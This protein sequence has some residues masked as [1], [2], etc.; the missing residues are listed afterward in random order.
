MTKLFTWREIM[1]RI[2]AAKGVT[3]R[4]IRGIKGGGKVDKDTSCWWWG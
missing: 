2:E 4:H 3:Y 1:A